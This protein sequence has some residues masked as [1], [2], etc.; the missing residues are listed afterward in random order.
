ML[1]GIA[2]LGIVFSINSHVVADQLASW[3]I[4]PQVERLTELSFPT[5]TALPTMYRADDTQ[6]VTF[7]IHNLEDRTTEYS[8]SV[9]ALAAEKE[10][11]LTEGSVTLARNQSQ[12]ITQTIT[13]P[14]L[15]RRVQIQVKLDYQAITLGHTEPIAQTQAIHYW[16]DKIDRKEGDV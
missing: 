5:Y 12:E 7:K 13:I 6:V 4:L 16:L 10:Q 15:D 2:A 11:T 8:Y 14:P 1:C 9:L 3:K